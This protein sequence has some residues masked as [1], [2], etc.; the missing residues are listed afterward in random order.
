MEIISD[1]IQKSKSNKIIL[2]IYYEIKP[3]NLFREFPRK[4]LLISLRTLSYGI[5][6]GLGHITAH[7]L[8]TKILS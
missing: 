1:K 5:V 7:F 4:L 8:V 3:R 6:F 2:E